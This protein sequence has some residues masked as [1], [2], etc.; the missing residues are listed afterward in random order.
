[1]IFNLCV[2]SKEFSAFL[3]CFSV[4]FGWWYMTQ[5][6]YYQKTSQEIYTHLTADNSLFTINPLMVTVTLSVEP[7]IFIRRCYWK[8]QKRS[9]SAKIIQGEVSVSRIK[10]TL[11]VD[12]TLQNV[13]KKHSRRPRTSTN[14]TKQERV[15]E[16]YRQS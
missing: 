2:V 4:V 6:S 8:F 3:L 13:R 9:W 5:L 11:D 7:N 16:T 14:T 12:E 15:L 1:M 10:G